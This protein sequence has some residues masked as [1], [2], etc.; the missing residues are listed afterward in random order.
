MESPRQTNIA[1][2]IP[3]LNARDDLPECLTALSRQQDVR[4]DTIVVDNGSTDG[5]AEYV[6]EQWPNVLLICNSS[7][8]GFARACNQ[9]IDAAGEGS[10]LVLLNSDTQVFPDWLSTLVA[11]MKADDSI[12]ITGSKTLYPNGAIEHAGGRVDSRGI[13]HHIGQGERERGE[14]NHMREVD[15]VTGASLAISPVAFRRVGKLDEMF[16]PIYYE[17]VDWC[18][19]VRRAGYRVVYAPH[20]RLIHKANSTMLHRGYESE[21]MVHRLRLRF[22]L[23]HWSLDELV[24]TFIP[25]ERRWLNS[26]GWQGEEIIAAMHRAYLYQ[27]LHLDEIVT[28]RQ[29]SFPKAEE[30]VDGLAAI[31]LGLRAVYPLRPASLVNSPGAFAA[32]NRPAIQPDRFSKMVAGFRRRYPRAS[33]SAL[34]SPITRLLVQLT[35]QQQLANVLV[36]YIRENNR[37]ISEL[38]QEVEVLKKQIAEHQDAGE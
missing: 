9:G 15:Y 24:D 10:I 36:E 32:G 21:Y 20:S 17:D 16:S 27:F 6:A 34:F 5:S 30:E 1:V 33:R 22:L 31:L 11:P 35:N 7:N 2:I 19:R 13:G 3:V 29:A 37:E 14:F 25:A 26:L 23:K 12:G 8:V 28:A 18:Y 4:F 38:A